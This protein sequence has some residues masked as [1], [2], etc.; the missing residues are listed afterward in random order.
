MSSNGPSP[1]FPNRSR[2]RDKTVQSFAILVVASFPILIAYFVLAGHPSIQTYTALP[3]APTDTATP[4]ST[5]TPTPKSTRSPKASPTS[6]QRVTPS[7]TP[8]PSAPQPIFKD[9]FESG[10]LSKWSV[11]PSAK[12]DL[13]VSG[14]AAYRGA[15]GLGVSVNHTQKIALIDDSPSLEAHYR[16]RFYFCPNS[17]TMTP[18]DY[19]YIFEAGDRVRK[20]MVFGVRLYRNSSGYNLGINASDDAGVDAKSPYFPITDAWHAV[21]IEWLASTA[22]AA[23]NGFFNLW[24]DGVLVGSISNIND[25]LL[26]VGRVYLGAPGGMDAGTSGTIFFDDFESRRRTYI[27]P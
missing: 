7:S 25:N 19:H 9:D 8:N 22:P 26:T 6:T 27:G 3:P 21:E 20:T 16:A 5:L 17:L 24:I 4:S 11:P 14:A 10:D 23:R 1:G 2:R 15:Y 13:S 12:G 18:G